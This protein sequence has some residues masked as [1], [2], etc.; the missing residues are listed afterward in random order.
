MKKL[1]Y[2]VLPMLIF[3]AC[4]K[5]ITSLNVE[6]KK[7]AVVPPGPLFTNATRNFA[8]NMASAS[9]NT[10][11]WRF[12]TGQ[13]AMTTYQD[14]VQYNFFTRN[15]PQA[16]WT[17]MYRD[18]LNDLKESARIINESVTITAGVKTNMLAQVDITQVLVWS[19]MVNT[20]GDVPYTEAL[21]PNSKLLP[22]YDDAKTVYTDLMKRLAADITALNT[23]SAGFSATEDLLYKG[24]V[25]NWIKFANALQM[26]M[27]ILL[28][29]SDPAAAKAAIEAADA[30]AFTSSADNAQFTYLGATP[31]TNPLYADIVLGGRGDYVAAEDLMNKLISLNDPR[32]TQFFKPNNAG[33]YVGGVSGRNN[34][35]SDYSQPSDKVSAAAAPQVLLDYAELEFIRAEAKE[36]GFTVA[37]TAEGHY[38]N[39]VTASIIWWGGSAADAAA[40]LA[41]PAVAYTTATGTYK[42]KIGTQ[43]WLA[44]YNRSVDA[45]TEVRRLDFPAITPPVKATS[46]FPNR[47]PY[48]NNEQQLNPA[49]YKAAAAKMGSDKV[50]FKLFWDKN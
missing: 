24:N 40:Y 26:K 46:G 14:E 42:Q 17:G 50:E 28:V 36:R 22:V 39:A 20:F 12:T 8:D 2:I 9:V 5:D 32:K 49:N 45:W 6:S 1:L 44:L 31:N 27:G 43:K 34:T 4:S 11:I 10:N 16:W 13:W 15:I 23:G 21:Q 25:A 35:L 48:P 33:A 41:Q 18:V 29:D 3:T 30:K 37:G 19:V 47:F 38:N 7:P